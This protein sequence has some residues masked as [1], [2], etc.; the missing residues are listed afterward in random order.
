MLVKTPRIRGGGANQ[1]PRAEPGGV[2]DPDRSLVAGEETIFQFQVGAVG[3]VAGARW[4]RNHRGGHRG[5][6]SEASQVSG[7]ITSNSAGHPRSA[8]DLPG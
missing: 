8:F 4:R 3:G 6:G 5:V 2:A 7:S 1:L